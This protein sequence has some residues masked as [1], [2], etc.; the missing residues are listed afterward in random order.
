MGG[1]RGEDP[2]PAG[3][4]TLW[5]WLGLGRTPPPR[6]VGGAPSTPPYPTRGPQAPRKEEDR[7]GSRGRCARA[8]G[9][10]RR[11]P[12]PGKGKPPATGDNCRPKVTVVLK[13]VATSDPE[14]GAT[15]FTMDVKGA[16]R[17]GRQL[18]A[19]PA[20]SLTVNA[21]LTAPGTTKVRRAGKQ[22]SLDALESGDRVLVQ[23]RLCKAAVAG[24]AAGDKAALE[25]SNGRA[26]RGPCSQDR[27]DRRR[28]HGVVAPMVTWKSNTLAA[29]R[30]F[31]ALSV[32]EAFRAY[33]IGIERR[34]QRPAVVHRSDPSTDRAPTIAAPQLRPSN[35]LSA[36]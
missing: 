28:H 2:P 15:G 30:P 8:A 24:D 33:A 13:G 3:E 26:S 10:R 29:G 20:T 36:C 23:F 4:N 19:D 14:S 34:V 11:A 32:R 27:L 9:R 17:H 31:E 7:A 5:G 12:P 35:G 18:V 21:D 6:G 25:G 1:G 16:N 22:S